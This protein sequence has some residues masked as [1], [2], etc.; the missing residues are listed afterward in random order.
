MILGR[1]FTV[2]LWRARKW[3]WAVTFGYMTKYGFWFHVV[4]VRSHGSCG[5]V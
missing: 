4:R 5:V 2:R 3:E 1:D